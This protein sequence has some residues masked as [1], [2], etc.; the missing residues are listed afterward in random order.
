ME[1]SGERNRSRRGEHD[2]KAARAAPD[3]CGTNDENRRS[4]LTA[5]DATGTALWTSPTRGYRLHADKSGNA[6]VS[7]AQGESFDPAG[8]LR[9]RWPTDAATKG[10]GTP[11][12]CTELGSASRLAVRGKDELYVASP[13]CPSVKALLELDASVAQSSWILTRVKLPP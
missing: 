13:A 7:G 10:A 3:D 2:T 9:H 5:L 6:Y 12:L 4:S 11:G 8:A 1:P